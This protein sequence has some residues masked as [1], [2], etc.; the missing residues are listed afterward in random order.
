MSIFTEPTLL[1][2]QRWKNKRIGILGGSFNPPH[3][4]HLHISKIALKSFRLDA[5]W[6][7]V[8]PQN[9]LKSATG[10]PDVKTRT[11]L[12]RQ[13]ID[14]H[15]KIL[16]T[17]IEEKLDTKYTYATVKKLKTHFPNT[18]FAW[19]TGMDN[20][21][22]LHKWNEWQNLLKE[23]CMIHITR[24]PPLG[25]VKQCPTK[26]LKTQKHRIINRGAAY[27]LDSQTTYW[28]LQKKTVNISSTEIRE[29]K[30][31]SAA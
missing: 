9:P 28:V 24:H 18:Q 14:N 3:E 10:L 12:G 21:H 11:A 30:I 17:G 26:M 25:L 6:W 31:K 20:A 19:I 27:P 1:N 22:S 8:T 15:P 23:I 13:I 2:A 4:G 7:L 16:V 5:V 29:N